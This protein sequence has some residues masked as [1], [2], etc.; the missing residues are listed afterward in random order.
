MAVGNPYRAKTDAG[1]GGP[2][3][4]LIS[5]FPRVG[6]MKPGLG[7]TMFPEGLL[8]LANMGDLEEDLTPVYDYID[9][10]NLTRCV[11]LFLE[12]RPPWMNTIYQKKYYWFLLGVFC[13]N[14]EEDKPETLMLYLNANIASDKRFKNIA[15]LEDWMGRTGDISIGYQLLQMGLSSWGRIRN[16]GDV[17]NIKESL[18]RWYS[19]KKKINNIVNRL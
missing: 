2:G 13:K 15:E 8:D 14:F 7:M 11:G 10:R 5:W 17:S 4:R 18:F 16:V 6:D 9:D 3:K 19:E 12:P 1:N